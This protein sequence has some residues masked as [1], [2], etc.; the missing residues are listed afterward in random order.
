MPDIHLIKE[1]STPV[2]DTQALEESKDLASR[3]KRSRRE[4]NA[5][6]WAFI[7]ILWII[8][9]GFGFA[10]LTRISMMIL[11]DRYCWLSD[12]HLKSLNDFITT[13][14]IGGVGGA[15]LKNKFP[16]SGN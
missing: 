7:I 16:S 14:G 11:P 15:L 3:Y 12:E 5:M 1:G 4:Q 2:S 10:I 13:G 9:A 8:V 6:H